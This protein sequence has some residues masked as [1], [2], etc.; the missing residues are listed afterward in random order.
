[1]AGMG[2]VRAPRGLRVHVARVELL[3]ELAAK[4]WFARLR[5][6]LHACRWLLV[7]VVAAQL[8][9]VITTQIALS[10][11]GYFEANGLMSGVV[12]GSPIGTLALKLGAV[13]AVL[14]LALVR[15]PR[16]RALVAVGL[17]LALSLIG[18]VANLAALLGR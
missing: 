17:A 15:L 14:A 6:N 3:L 11:G 10:R 16:S 5:P 12:Y 7:A 18:P 2:Q 9:D 13:V 1:M 8:A 4:V